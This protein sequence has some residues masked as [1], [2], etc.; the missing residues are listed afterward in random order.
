MDKRGGN[1]LKLI[2]LKSSVAMNVVK[3]TT[4]VGGSKSVKINV[5]GI[6]GKFPDWFS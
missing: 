3:K 4:V 6:V 2:R 1:V 5:R